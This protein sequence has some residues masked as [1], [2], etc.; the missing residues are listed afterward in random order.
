MEIK[1]VIL[2]VI[3]FINLVVIP[4]L[5]ISL[6]KKKNKSR[7]SKTG[8]EDHF[9]PVEHYQPDFPEDKLPLAKLQPWD[10]FNEDEQLSHYGQ[11]TGEIHHLTGEEREYRIKKRKKRIAREKKLYAKKAREKRREEAREKVKQR[12]RESKDTAMAAR[13]RFEQAEEELRQMLLAEKEENGKQRE[14]K[15]S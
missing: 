14:S 15:P 7:K 9:Q 3:I 12:E 6:L 2:C 1:Y 10:Y 4:F 13:D 5:Y 8:D 11:F